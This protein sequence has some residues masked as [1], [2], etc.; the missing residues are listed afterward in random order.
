MK[1]PL[2]GSESP[3]SSATPT[4]PPKPPIKLDLGCGKNKREG[5][6]GVD[7]IKFDTVDFQANLAG[8][9]WNFDRSVKEINGVELVEK[10]AVQGVPVMYWTL[11]DNSVDEAH[12]SHFIEH[13]EAQERIWFVNE[14]HR[15]LKPGA[16]ITLIVP[17]WASDRAYGDMTHKWPPVSGF[18][19][20]YLNRDWRLGVE[21]QFPGNAPHD[22][23]SYNPYGYDCDFDAGWGHGTVS[24]YVN[25]PVDTLNEERKAHHSTHFINFRT[26]LMARLTKKVPKQT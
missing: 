26:D 13:L 8:K 16:F 22:D 25:A 14:L 23:I 24:H 10:E 11:P 6:L 12:C 5:F 21:G 19:F 15:V 7:S 17:D 18:W 2:P 3:V 4:E 20:F 1:N 9:H